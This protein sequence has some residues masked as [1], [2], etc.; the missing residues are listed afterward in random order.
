LKEKPYD[1][2]SAR[3]QTQAVIEAGAASSGAT[4]LEV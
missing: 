1:S 4:S 2:F 3:P